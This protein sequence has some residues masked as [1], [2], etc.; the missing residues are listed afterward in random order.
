MKSDIP[1]ESILGPILFNIFI[2]DIDDQMEYAHSKFVDNTK[3]NNAV[4]LLEGWDAIQ[5]DL[6]KLE[7]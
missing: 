4:D 2:H 3:L 6:D 5:R 1:R 7:Q